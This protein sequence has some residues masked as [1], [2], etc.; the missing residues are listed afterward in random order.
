MNKRFI[1]L[2]CKEPYY[3]CKIKKHWWSMWKFETFTADGKSF[4]VVYEDTPYGFKKL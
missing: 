1:K 2:H 4:M 3:V